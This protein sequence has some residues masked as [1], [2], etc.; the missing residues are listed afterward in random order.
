MTGAR[1]AVT[2]GP[3]GITRCGN[4]SGRTSSN[5]FLRQRARVYKNSSTN[6]VY[7]VSNQLSDAPHRR[8][9]N[10]FEPATPTRV[11]SVTSR[12]AKWSRPVEPTRCPHWKEKGVADLRG[13]YG[14][15]PG[16]DS[17]GRRRLRSISPKEFQILTYNILPE[18]QEDLA[19]Q[20]DYTRSS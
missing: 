17:G 8:T 9:P 1:K 15:P 12:A 4:T 18:G 5:H 13:S 10:A 20:T 7:A 2:N 16:P 6:V 19:V 3:T 14:A 11:S